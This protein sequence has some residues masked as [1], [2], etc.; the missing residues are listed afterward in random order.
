MREPGDAFV[1]PRDEPE[2]RLAALWQE[3]LRLD[4]VS[5]HAD[6]FA[7]GGHSLLATQ[8]VSR[9]RDAF[10]VELALA[11]L[12]EAP[13]VA[14]LAVAIDQAGGGLGDETAL[15]EAVAELEGLSEEETRF[16]LEGSP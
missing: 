13:T 3:V 11:R 4:R 9:V 6:F 1:A 14:E 15:A 5:V 12:F 8:L 2:Q 7:L 16:L 10:Q